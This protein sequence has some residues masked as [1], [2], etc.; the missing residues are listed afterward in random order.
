M[1]RVCDFQKAKELREK[2]NIKPIEAK[3]KMPLPKAYFWA[4][5][6]LNRISLIGYLVSL[7]GILVSSNLASSVRIL[8]KAYFYFAAA[9]IV[10]FFLWLCS[11]VYNIFWEKKKH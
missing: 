1:I 8:E 7:I 6:G 4:K 5:G 3:E 10:F 9:F 11:T 2:F